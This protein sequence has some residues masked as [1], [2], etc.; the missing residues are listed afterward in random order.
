MPTWWDSLDSVT[1]V[2]WWLRWAGAALTM[3]GA[4]CVI[5]TLATSKRAENLRERRDADRSLTKEQTEQILAVLRGRPTATIELEYPVGDPEVIR[6]TEQI[7]G[8][9]KAAGW[10]VSGTS[11]AIYTGT[12]T[13]LI[14]VVANRSDPFALALHQAFKA[15][16]IDAPGELRPNQKAVKLIVGHKPR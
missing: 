16:G 13:G 10:R 1:N 2:T 14:L 7:E 9:L 11:A 4:L 12:P 6:F 15:A 3:V 5:A 8:V